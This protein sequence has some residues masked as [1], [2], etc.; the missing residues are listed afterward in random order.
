MFLTILIKLAVNGKVLAG[1]TVVTFG[2]EE[3]EIVEGPE[4]LRSS[5][6]CFRFFDDVCDESVVIPVKGDSSGTCSS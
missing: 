5:S 3:L 4:N 6:L 1:P 2:F